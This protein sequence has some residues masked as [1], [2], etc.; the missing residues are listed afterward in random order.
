MSKAS[1]NLAPC[2]RCGR[3]VRVGIARRWPA[4]HI[5]TTC[6]V[7]AMETYATCA[8]CGRHRIT[9]GLDP[10]GHPLCPPC[11]GLTVPFTCTRCDREALRYSEDACGHCVLSERLALL[12]DDG[13]GRI[14]PELLPFHQ[15]VCQMSRPRAGILWISKPHVPP[16]LTALARSQVPLTHDG[17]STLTPWRSVIH[18]R[19]LLIACG[20]LSP[21]DR[22]LLLFEQW[23]ATWLAGIPD[24][25]HRRLLQRF[26]TW[27][28]LRRLR[29]AAGNGPL[30]Y[31]PGQGARHQLVQSA[32][33]LT[34]LATRDRTLRECA[35][36]D[37]DNYLAHP[38][39]ARVRAIP[40]LRWCITRKEMPRLAITARPA[41]ERQPVSQHE[42]L[43]IIRRLAEDHELDLRD[44]IV[45]LLVLLYAQPVTR[46][47]RLTTSDVTR[48]DGTLRIRLGDPP[49]PVPEPFATLIIRYL[50]ARPNL[51][52]ATNPGSPLL[53][54]GRRAGQPMHPTSLRRRLTAAGIPNI[55]GRTAALRQLL[56]Q[57]P[58]PVIAS[59]LCYH[60]H[61]AERVA[62]A[63]GATWKNY[64]PGDH[65]R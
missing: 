58:A 37:I 48:D 15:H 60:A 3:E 2:H 6:F 8:G 12:L 41:G 56:L 62:A 39:Q 31:A 52:T 28:V 46:I 64:A 33:F 14:R 51:A 35:Q 26:A 5:C 13:T 24:E 19:D 57:A 38:G 18:V 17:L 40:F 9:P 30:G 43:G 34:W 1:P 7:A 11:A 61:S 16:I 10:A 63:A 55:T 53:F 29:N 32:A 47:T 22:F 36:A 49:A 50:D 54:P 65:T 27:H 23:L 44:R 59:M 25:S 20:V 45:A 4:G 21:A 42:R